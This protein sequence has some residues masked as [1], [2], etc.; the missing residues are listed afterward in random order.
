MAHSIPFARM[1]GLGNEIL[2]AD[3]RGQSARITPEAA[4]ALAAR[5]ETHFDQIMAIHDPVSAGTFAYVR[6]LNSDGTEAGAC[7]NGTRCVVQA[8]SAETGQRDFLFETKAGLLEAFEREDGLLTVD[9]GKPRFDWQSIPLSEEFADT[10]AIELQIGPIDAPILHSPSVASMGNPHAIFWVKDD[11]WSFALDR[12]GPILEH[13]PLFPD[14]ANIS[15]A[16]VTGPES[17][18][19]RTWERGAGLTRACGSAACAAAVSAART[20]RT[21]RSV[22][23]TVPG[24][25]LRIEW[26]SDD[27]VLMTGPAE[28]EWSGTLDPATGA[29]ARDEAPAEV[30]P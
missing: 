10:R 13:H 22:T 28:W 4:R 23:V 12:F 27:H 15:L 5:A 25:D 11:V 16:Q 3:L 20:G 6:I 30:M 26:R 17:L 24:G 1:N 19:I 7:G 29:F 14:R 21:G 18:R 8:L 9:M 2:V